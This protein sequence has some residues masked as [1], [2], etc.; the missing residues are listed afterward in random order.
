MMTVGG[1]C[2]Q[3]VRVGGPT[4]GA[5]RGDL[6]SSVSGDAQ[7][8]CPSRRCRPNA[9]SSRGGNRNAAV[10]TDA[11]RCVQCDIRSLSMA[12]FAE[13][14]KNANTSAR[15][16]LSSHIIFRKASASFCVDRPA[17]IIAVGLVEVTVGAG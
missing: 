11:W 6:A 17:F 8:R 14:Q 9:L 7:T 2:M 12:Q 1:P 15:Y 5:S 3:C 16:K 4:C 10:E 13:R